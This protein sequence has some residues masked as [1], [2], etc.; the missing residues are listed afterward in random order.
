MVIYSIFDNHFMT[1]TNNKDEND[2]KEEEQD[3]TENKE[4]KTRPRWIS[5]GYAAPNKIRPR[6]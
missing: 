5:K 4:E 3:R 6:Q 1:T 2:K